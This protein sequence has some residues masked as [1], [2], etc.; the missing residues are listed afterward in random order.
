MS[1]NNELEL[2]TEAI[3]SLSSAIAREEKLQAAENAVIE[4]VASLDDEN[5][6][7]TYSLKEGLEERLHPYNELFAKQVVGLDIL[8]NIRR[9]LFAPRNKKVEDWTLNADG[10]R[11]YH[12]NIKYT[13]EKFDQLWNLKPSLYSQSL[14]EGSED[15]NDPLLKLHFTDGK[16]TSLSLDWDVEY[17]EG[18]WKKKQGITKLPDA[19][20][21]NDVLSLPDF[22]TDVAGECKRLTLFTD[23]DLPSMVY[24]SGQ[25]RI[26][27]HLDTQAK[28]SFDSERNMFLPTK[29]APVEPGE[30]RRLDDSMKF[31]TNFFFTISGFSGRSIEISTRREKKVEV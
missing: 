25:K 14:V 27:G 7:N 1:R 11:G 28:F 30:H 16:I 20:T 18:S 31:V 6:T 21:L 10:S 4:R 23:T 12:Y 17:N 13:R 8:Q 19:E 3:P 5:I 22:S 2:S 29:V 26:F 15:P 24:S 9:G